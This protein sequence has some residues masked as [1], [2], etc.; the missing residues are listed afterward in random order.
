PEGLYDERMLEKMFRQYIRLIARAGE[1]PTASVDEET[2]RFIETYN[3]TFMR[4]E[5]R[6]KRHSQTLCDLFAP[7]F[8]TYARRI[9]VKDFEKEWDYQTLGQAVYR[10][11]AKLKKDGVKPGDCVGITGEQGGN[12]GGHSG[13]SLM[14]SGVCSYKRRISP[15]QSG[16]HNEKNRW[17]SKN[18][19]GVCAGGNGERTGERI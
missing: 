11:C 10:I 4:E 17:E 6:A 9:A 15:G 5:E 7:S 12:G 1:N 8:E 18:R 16:I 19:R 13:G 2:E 14:R 3:H